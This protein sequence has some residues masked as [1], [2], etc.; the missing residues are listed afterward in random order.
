M[1]IDISRNA[2]VFQKFR[3]AEA[4]VLRLLPENKLRKYYSLNAL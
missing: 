4:C 1:R 2:S 3:E